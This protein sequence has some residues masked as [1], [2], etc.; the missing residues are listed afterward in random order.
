MKKILWFSFLFCCA[1]AIAQERPAIVQNAIYVGAEGKFE[2]T[3]DTALI[4]FNVADQE[5]RSKDAY[6]KVAKGAEQVRKVLRDNGIDPKTAQ[7]SFYSLQPMYDR[8]NSKPKVVGYRV[9]ANVTLKL[10]EKDFGKAGTMLQQLSDIEIAENQSL[11]YQLDDVEAAKIKAVGDGLLRAKGE[12]EAVAI[13][14]GRSLGQL[15]YASIDTTEIVP[16]MTQSASDMRTLARTEAAPP[17]TEFTPQLITVTA[18]VNAL[19][20]LK[21]ESG[22]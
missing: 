3:P 5:D 8:K 9:S 1:C 6:D 2:A 10:K 16:M 21:P 13:T 7:F 12:A 17:T 15:I 4:Q 18:H 19:F 22:H 11:S 14:G 20:G